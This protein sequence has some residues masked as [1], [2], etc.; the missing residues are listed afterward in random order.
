LLLFALKEATK[1]NQS[2]KTTATKASKPKH[3][4][5]N[6]QINARKQVCVCSAELKPG[7]SQPD[8]FGK[9]VSDLNVLTR[10]NGDNAELQNEF[11][12]LKQ[13]IFQVGLN[14]GFVLLRIASKRSQNGAISG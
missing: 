13:S 4:K 5:Q 10:N 11:I 6:K 8:L 7:K 14:F 12:L 2:K 9:K 1:S 3:T